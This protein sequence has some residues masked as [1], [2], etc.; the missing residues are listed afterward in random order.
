MARRILAAV[1]FL[2]SLA[3]R[4]PAGDLV[5]PP[6]GE[7]VRFEA[8]E[9]VRIPLRDPLGTG[10]IVWALPY[11]V[12]NDTGRD[13][14]L[15]LSFLMKTDALQTVAVPEPERPGAGPDILKPRQTFAPVR[16][17]ARDHPLARRRLVEMTGETLPSQVEI[18][19]DIRAGERKQG[20]ALFA[21]V[22]IDV[23]AFQ[24][25][26]F[27][28]CPVLRATLRDDAPSFSHTLLRPYHLKRFLAAGVPV[29]RLA[30]AGEDLAFET[31][32]REIGPKDY[33]DEVARDP[34]KE[35][36]FE[37]DGAYYAY[38][39]PILSSPD[40]TVLRQ[41]WVLQLSFARV[42]DAARGVEDYTLLV[43][44]R[45]ILGLSEEAP[46]CE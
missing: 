21:E 11:A 30:G 39:D 41:R 33:L 15:S 34:D 28:L 4:A 45:W 37:R 25:Y 42:N 22:P 13:R 29:V 26:V 16:I 40:G 43:G 27:G 18:Q 1:G 6:P 9:V 44:R 5:V 24:I 14:R 12:V 35:R 20:A 10:R 23:H 2:A 3:A 19:G 17:W 46:P 31:L 38:D 36:V 7:T 32:V 8:G